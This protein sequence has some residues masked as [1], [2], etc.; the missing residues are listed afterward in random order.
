MLFYLNIVM[1]KDR[2]FC[3]ISIITFSKTLIVTSVNDFIITIR[4]L[5]LNF[6]KR[7]T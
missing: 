5:I 3:Y 4:F 2:F 6:L 7:L 1:A